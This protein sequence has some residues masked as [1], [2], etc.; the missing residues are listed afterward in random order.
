MMI[1]ESGSGSIPLTNGSGSRR[2]KNIPI[3]IRIRNTASY[4]SSEL[5]PQVGDELVELREGELAPWWRLQGQGRLQQA[6]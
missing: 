4:L 2:P 3:R 1:E 6:A 5:G